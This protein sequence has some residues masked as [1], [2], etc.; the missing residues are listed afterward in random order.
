MIFIL[1]GSPNRT[2]E[3]FSDY[4]YI[5]DTEAKRF[6]KHTQKLPYPMSSY[7]Q[8]ITVTQKHGIYLLTSNVLKHFEDSIIHF[9]PSD[10]TVTAIC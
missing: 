5:Y 1:G 6:L 9:D 2:G 8:Q 3:N 10:G 7:T 4:I